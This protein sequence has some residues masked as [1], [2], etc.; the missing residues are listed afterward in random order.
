MIGLL[1]GI[2]LILGCVF[3]LGFILSGYRVIDPVAKGAGWPVRLM[4][5]PGAIVLWPLLIVKW[6]KRVRT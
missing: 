3:G 5:L 1:A 4:W 2:Y 6:Y